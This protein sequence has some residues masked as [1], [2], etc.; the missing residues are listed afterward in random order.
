MGVSMVPMGGLTSQ[1]PSGWFDFQI[2]MVFHVVNHL[3]V[4]VRLLDQDGFS[5]G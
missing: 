3:I 1:Q 5:C 2:K 4:M